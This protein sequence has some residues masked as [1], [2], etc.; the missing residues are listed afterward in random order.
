MTDQTAPNLI[1]IEKLQRKRRL[2][3]KLSIIG[4]FGLLLWILLWNVWLAPSPL[5][6]V[7][8]SFELAV[9]LL[10]LAFLV[11]G[12]LYGKVA[13]HAYASFAAIFYVFIGFWFTFTPDEMLYGLL[14][15]G[16]SSCLYFGGFFYARLSD[17]ID[18]H[19]KTAVD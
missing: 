2:W 4:L 12:I 5:Q 10:P 18:Q 7:P 19:S 13:A 16:W 17:A 9:L 1:F 11:R 14:I 15:L 8:L 3:H 6:V